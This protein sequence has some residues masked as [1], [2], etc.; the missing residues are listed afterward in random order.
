MGT[1]TVTTAELTDMARK[2][3][4]AKAA[5]EAAT[6]ALAD[7]DAMIM[8][9][10]AE[11]GIKTIEDA[12]GKVTLTIA[13]GTTEK[14]DEELL[15]ARIN[16]RSSLWFKITRRRLDTTAWKHA[17]GLGLVKPEV[18]EAVTKRTTKSPYLVQ[19]VK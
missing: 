13:Q 12:S 6:N 5:V 2:R 9:A 18:V 7:L 11:H 16:P 14:V 19:S 10:M 8:V 3:F 1:L 4:E 15:A 17:V